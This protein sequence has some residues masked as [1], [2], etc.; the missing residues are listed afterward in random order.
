MGHGALARASS[1]RHSARLRGRAAG[2]D[3]GLEL[4]AD[5]GAQPA[6]RRTGSMW[7]RR[8]AVFA[9]RHIN[10]AVTRYGL[11]CRCPYAGSAGKP[12]VCAPSTA[13]GPGVL[14]S[15][16]FR[17]KAPA[18]SCR[19]TGHRWLHRRDHG[20]SQ[21]KTERRSLRRQGISHASGPSS[22]AATPGMAATALDLALHV[23]SGPVGN[24]RAHSGSSERLEPRRLSL[25]PRVTG[26]QPR[27][28]PAPAPRQMKRARDRRRG[29]ITPRLI[30]VV[31]TN[32]AVFRQSHAQHTDLHQIHW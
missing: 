18:G 10:G 12:A 13:G 27:R 16:E 24:A 28:L 22:P 1:R 8:G 4:A 29:D 2:V 23:L 3:I 20:V 5:I 19:T 15:L 32:G 31:T 21:D 11:Q 7:A 6:V 26:M 17:R 30:D 9:P 14:K 25:A